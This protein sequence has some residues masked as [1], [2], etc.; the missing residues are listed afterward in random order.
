MV[1]MVKSKY[2]VNVGSPKNVNNSNFKK[3]PRIWTHFIHVYQRLWIS[4]DFVLKLT[5]G[6]ISE[7]SKYTGLSDKR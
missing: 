3:Q 7:K 5:E 4:V 2:Y 6:F 1:F